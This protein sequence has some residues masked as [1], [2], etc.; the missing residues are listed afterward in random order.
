MVSTISVLRCECITL[1]KDI[2]KTKVKMLLSRMQ[3]FL[4]LLPIIWFYKINDHSNLLLICENIAF[5]I[6]MD[7]FAWGKKGLKHVASGKYLG[8]S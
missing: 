3:C 1:N 5:E 8:Y 2:F 4:A 6:Q 7:Y